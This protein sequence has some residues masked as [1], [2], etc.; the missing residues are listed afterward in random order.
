MNKYDFFKTV[1]KEIRLERGLTQEKFA[2]N[3]NINEKYYG[4]IERGK[5][6][7]SVKKLFKI[8]DEH[9]IKLSDI[10][11]RIEQKMKRKV[12]S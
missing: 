6:D 3:A 7:L 4:R 1:L 2:L 12:K 9:N 11:N 5:S 8:C 10:E